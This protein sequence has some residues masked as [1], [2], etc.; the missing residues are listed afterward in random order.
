[1][2]LVEADVNHDQ[3]EDDVCLCRLTYHD[4]SS[5]FCKHLTISSLQ[6]TVLTEVTLLHDDV[7]VFDDADDVDDDA[8]DYDCDDYDGD[9]NTCDEQF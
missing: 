1:M 2:L 7:D 3:T 6:L 8:D 9:A 5:M 4:C